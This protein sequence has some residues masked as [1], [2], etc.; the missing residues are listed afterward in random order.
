VVLEMLVPPEEQE[1]L[2]EEEVDPE[3]GMRLLI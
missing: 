1:L 2:A 3:D